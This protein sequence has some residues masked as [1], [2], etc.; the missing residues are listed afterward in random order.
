MT[1]DGCAGSV[2]AASYLEVAIMVTLG[3]LSFSSYALDVRLS[4]VH[5]EESI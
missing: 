3:Q 4:C 1:D 5:G 2:G